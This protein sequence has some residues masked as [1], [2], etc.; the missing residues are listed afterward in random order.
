[1]IE[2]RGKNELTLIVLKDRILSSRVQYSKY[3][4]PPVPGRSERS[5]SSYVA[6]CNRGS[7]RKNDR[8]FFIDREFE[9]RIIK[10]S[11]PIVHH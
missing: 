5:N 7:R 2:R 1:M 11:N 8:L 3:R 4:N 10:K 6:F 9:L